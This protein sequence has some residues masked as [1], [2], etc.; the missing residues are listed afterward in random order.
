MIDDSFFRAAGRFFRTLHC[1]TRVK[2]NANKPSSIVITFTKWQSAVSVS[3]RSARWK[4]AET[5]LRQ[6]L[7]SAT[8][9]AVTV[10]QA[11]KIPD[12]YLHEKEMLSA[13]ARPDENCRIVVLSAEVRRNLE[14]YVGRLLSGRGF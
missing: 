8:R 9:L 11:A 10:A 3:P 6:R 14:K 12:L 4:E 1:I 2:S 5:R 7:T 13:R